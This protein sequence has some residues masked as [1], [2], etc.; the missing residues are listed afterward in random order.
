MLPTIECSLWLSQYGMMRVLEC[1]AQSL[2]ADI[3]TVQV[4][5]LRSIDFLCLCYFC[6]PDRV[7]H[8]GWASSQITHHASSY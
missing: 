2:A 5:S 7:T 8:H 6:Q 1:D 3:I 4:F